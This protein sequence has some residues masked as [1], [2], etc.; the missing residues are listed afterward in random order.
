MRQ[1]EL[2]QYIQAYGKDLFSFCRAVTRSPQEAEDLYQDTFLKL[3]EIG[4]QVVITKNPKSY[5]MGIA[6]N[7][8]RNERRKL[9]VRRRIA[10]VW[11]SVE[12]MD[13]D[14]AADVRLLEEEVVVREECAAVRGAVNALPDRYRLPVLL[15]Y[16]EEL[17]LA[18]IAAV[19]KLP[20]GTVKSRLHRAKQILRQKLGA[21][22]A[23][24]LPQAGKG[25]WS[26]K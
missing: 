2:E 10:G 25:A 14:I 13:E 4:E 17:S 15:F 9:S 5:L 20:E 12:E 11:Q 21:L 22:V 6:V 24:E 18:E 1:E 19:L 7:R 3:Y 26:E 16:M 8:Y 23:E